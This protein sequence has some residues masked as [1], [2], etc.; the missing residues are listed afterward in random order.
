MKNVKLI[1]IVMSVVWT[2]CSSNHSLRPTLTDM[3]VVAHIDTINGES[4]TVCQLDLLED[5]VRLPLSALVEE[6]QIIRLDN[7]DEALVELGGVHFSDNYILIQGWK[8]PCKLFRKDG[9]YINKVG[10]IGQGPGEYKVIHDV[11]IDEKHGHIYLLPWTARAILVYNLEGKFE[12]TI[13]LHL[14]HPQMTV[15]K[16]IFHVDREKNQVFVASLPFNYL[17]RMAWVQDLEGNLQDV[18]PAGHLKL[19]PNYSNE[20]ICEK[21]TEQWSFHLSP[22]FELRKDSLYHWNLPERKLIPRF[23]LDFGEREISLHNYY[24]LPL[25]YYGS[26]SSTKQMTE[27]SFVS[28]REQFFI[29]D[30][31]TLHGSFCHIYNDYLCDEPTDWIVGKGGYYIENVE[32]SALLERIGKWLEETPEQ[33]TDRRKRLLALKAGIGRNDN[34]YIIYGKHRTEK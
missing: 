15:A 33:D 24:E 14:P 32:P 17:P 34:N 18:I 1:L 22:F 26:V 10:S 7:R 8:T 6:L 23:T 29:V 27:D 21:R 3:P 12:G 31:S 13:P 4:L 25:Y 11:Q 16:G 30:K 19:K 2:A 28:D 20:L 9:T 5:T